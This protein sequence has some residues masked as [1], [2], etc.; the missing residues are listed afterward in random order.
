MGDE[1]VSA[2]GVD[3]R[4]LEPFGPRRSRLGLLALTVSWATSACRPPVST[5]VCSNPS[6]LAARA[7]TVTVC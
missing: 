4:L 1:R 7:P 3:S 5:R 2:S 6:G